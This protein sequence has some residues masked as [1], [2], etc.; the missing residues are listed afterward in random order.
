MLRAFR[1]FVDSN[2]WAVLPSDLN[3]CRSLQ[4][5]RYVKLNTSQCKDMAR[6][7]TSASEPGEALN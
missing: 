3:F 7:Q 4:I 5:S 1:G 2:R 6:F